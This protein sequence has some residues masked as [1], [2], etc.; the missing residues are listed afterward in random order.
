MSIVFCYFLLG[1]VEF[2]VALGV[3]LILIPDPHPSPLAPDEGHSVLWG[4]ACVMLFTEKGD[5]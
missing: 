5:L 3:C 4:G 1:W 2:G